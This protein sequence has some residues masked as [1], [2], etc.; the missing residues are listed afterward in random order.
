MADK[1]AINY[2]MKLPH[3]QGYHR[4]TFRTKKAANLWMAANKNRL[5]WHQFV[6]LFPKSS[7]PRPLVKDEPGPDYVKKTGT[8]QTH[9]ETGME[10]L[11]LVFYDENAP[12]GPPNPEYDPSK[13]EDRRN[14]KHFSTY[15]A[16]T[17]IGN[18][19]ILQ[20]PSGEKVFMIR[21]RDFAIQD[22]FNIS[23]YPR[24]FTKKEWI[25]LF[26]PENVKVTLWVK[27]KKNE[28]LPSGT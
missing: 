26:V 7:L 2:T 9:F 13:P 1:Y 25:E 23:F 24:G 20:L 21:D 14:F 12:K 17:F 10:C 5:Y 27:E 19:M 18:G 16:L 8:L 11:G 15:E 4:E 3:P 6:Y 22:G 28:T